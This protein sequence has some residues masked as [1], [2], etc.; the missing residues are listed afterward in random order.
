MYECFC[1]RRPS[2][3]GT[4]LAHVIVIALLLALPSAPAAAF[5][6]PAV[7]GNVTLATPDTGDFQLGVVSYSELPFRTV[8]HQQFDYSC[9]SAA[10]A[11]MLRYNY[12]HITSEAEVFKA[13]Y[14]VGDQPQIQK[15]GFSLLDMK[16]YLASQG[17]QADGYRLTVGDLAR[18]ATPAIA[19]VQ[20][21]SYKH[22]VVIKGVIKDNL[23]I[24]DPARGLQLYTATDF[25]KIWNG[26][27][28]LI[29]DATTPLHITFNGAEEWSH[30]ADSHPF[31]A[32]VL[33]QPLAPFTRD[34]RV[35]YQIRPNQVIPQVR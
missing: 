24:G 11:S 34:L 3:V 17:Y 25:M 32:T 13:M 9:G 21:G 18:L 16:K 22:F 1:R 23:L 27:A 7:V 12:A 8:L 28:F 20:I 19:L 14:A 35:I 33:G 30:W 15:L 4:V 5:T 10:L 26:I 31:A 2:Q 6:G 29:H